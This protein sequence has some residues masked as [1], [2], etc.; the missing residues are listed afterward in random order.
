M[1]CSKKGFLL[2]S[3]LLKP[4]LTM[5]VS[6][7]CESQREQL[8]KP[9][10][11]SGWQLVENRDAIIKKYTFQDFIEA[12]GFMTR[13]AL[14]AEKMDHHPEWFNVYNRVEITLSTHDCGGLSEKDIELAKFCDKNVK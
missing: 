9:L 3:S 2:F 13:I 1:L 10:L 4:K 11:S 8:L 6:T 14:K 12:F 7:L 5:S